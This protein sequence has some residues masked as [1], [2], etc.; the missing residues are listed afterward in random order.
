MKYKT[1]NLC[2]LRKPIEQFFNEK[3]NKSDGKRGRC[4]ICD[5]ASR[6]DYILNNKDRMRK[7]DRAKYSSLSENEKKEYIKK[8]SLQ[9]QDRMRKNPQA[10]L[11]KK[12]YDKSDRGIYSRYRC[13]AKRRAIVFEL[14]FDIFSDLLER[15]CFYCGKAQSRGVDRYDSNLGYTI[16]NCVAC[17]SDCNE[18][19]MDRS[20]YD[21][22]KHILKMIKHF[23]INKDE[24]LRLS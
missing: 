20:A 23:K 16:D 3:G 22:F 5:K 4:K 24:I 15:D 7:R 6:V 19:K 18:I 11:A 13:D 2:K 14:D 17:C 8:K 10:K 1:C 12:I 9:N 21:M